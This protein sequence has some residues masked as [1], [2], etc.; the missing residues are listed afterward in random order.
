MFRVHWL[1]FII[2]LTKYWLGIAALDFKILINVRVKNICLF[3]SLFVFFKRANN[4]LLV[5]FI[6]PTLRSLTLYNTTF[7]HSQVE[8]KLAEEW[9]RIK[10]KE[11]F[12][13]GIVVATSETLTD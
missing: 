1:H 3:S 11:K 8:G 12:E 7:T 5:R 2:H 9:V 10:N 13:G 6:N 4:A